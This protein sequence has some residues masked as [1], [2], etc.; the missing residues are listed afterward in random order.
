MQQTNPYANQPQQPVGRTVNTTTL[1]PTQTQTAVVQGNITQP[2]NQYPYQQQP[3]LNAG[4]PQQS[5]FQ[6]ANQVSQLVPT[7]MQSNMSP[8]TPSRTSMVEEHHSDRLRSS[9]DDA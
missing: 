6:A 4:N 9:A 5:Q 3:N 1:A 7:V 8:S 2:T